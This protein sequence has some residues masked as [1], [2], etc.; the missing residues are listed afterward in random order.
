MVHKHHKPLVVARQDPYPWYIDDA[1]ILQ[2]E[3]LLAG[4]G[5]MAAMI[6]ISCT[7]TYR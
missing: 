1:A 3:E 2:R 4:V 7:I 6:G 5:W